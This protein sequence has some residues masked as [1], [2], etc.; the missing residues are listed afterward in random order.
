M[1]KYELMQK[2]FSLD[3][4]RMEL[5]NRAANLNVEIQDTLKQLLT[6]DM[7]N[8]GIVSEETKLVLDTFG[9]QVEENQRVEKT[10]Y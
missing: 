10:N 7:S 5:E 1:D 9:F 4:Q 6:M 8:E 2:V 3:S